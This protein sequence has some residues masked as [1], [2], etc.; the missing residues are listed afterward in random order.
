MTNYLET[1]AEMAARH[2]RER[3]E[4]LEALNQSGYS[5]TEAGRILGISHRVVNR[6]AQIYEIDWKFKHKG[7]A[8]E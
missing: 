2:K 8:V 7:R 3:I 4:A 1:W 5:Q 6:W